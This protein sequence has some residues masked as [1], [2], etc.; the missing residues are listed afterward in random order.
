[1]KRFTKILLGMTLLTLES[2]QARIDWTGSGPYPSYSPQPYQTVAPYPL[3][4]QQA[5]YVRQAFADMEY[6]FQNNHVKCRTRGECLRLDLSSLMAFV[7]MNPGHPAIPLFENIYNLVRADSQRQKFSSQWVIF[8]NLSPQRQ[9]EFRNGLR[10]AP[11]RPQKVKKPWGISW[12]SAPATFNQDDVFTIVLEEVDHQHKNCEGYVGCVTADVQVINRVRD[13]L[14]TIDPVRT[15]LAML[16]EILKSK[17]NQ[18]IFNASLYLTLY[19]PLKPDW[20]DAIRKQQARHLAGEGYTQWHQ[21]ERN[22]HQAHWYS[23]RITNGTPVTITPYGQG[24]AFT[25]APYPVA[26]GSPGQNNP[27]KQLLNV[28][29]QYARDYVNRW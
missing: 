4:S 12:I 13:R 24:T 9:N 29:K 20:Y 19:N 6:A 26:P 18:T 7:N 16:R 28:T 10:I 23:A 25:P 5:P 1:M 2:V 27:F 14:S 22:P 11:L 8:Q 17:A 15:S 3:S 21:I